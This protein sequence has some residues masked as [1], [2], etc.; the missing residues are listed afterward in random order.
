MKRRGLSVRTRTGFF[1]V[2][3]PPVET[4]ELTAG[5]QIKKALMSPFGASAITVRLTN[6]FTNLKTGSLLRSLIYISAQDLVFGDEPDNFHT[7]TFDLG[8]ILFG[9]NG[10]I[11]D[12]QSRAVTLRLRDDAYQSALRNGIVY[13]LDTPLKQAGA[14]QFRIAIRDQSLRA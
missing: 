12:L 14:L 7:A 6:L 13:T 4:S 9:D 2:D 5:D 11:N 10:H 1:G 3:K 8:I